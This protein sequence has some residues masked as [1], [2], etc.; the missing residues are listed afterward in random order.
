MT[1]TSNLSVGKLLLVF[2][3]RWVKYRLSHNSKPEHVVSLCIVLVTWHFKHLCS[4]KGQIVTAYILPHEAK[5][6]NYPFDM[7]YLEFFVVLTGVCVD[8]S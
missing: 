4:N 2:C 6:R 3:L 5:S 1:V 8:I 7:S